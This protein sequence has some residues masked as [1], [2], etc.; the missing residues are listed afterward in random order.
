MSAGEDVLPN[1]ILTLKFDEKSL[2]SLE[3][4]EFW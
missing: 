1:G 4:C 3:P 2:P